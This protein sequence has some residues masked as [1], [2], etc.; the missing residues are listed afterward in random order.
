MKEEVKEGGPVQ[1]EIV[2]CALK[3]VRLEFKTDA[4]QQ[5]I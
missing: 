3:L 4:P 2:L 5:Q 1:K